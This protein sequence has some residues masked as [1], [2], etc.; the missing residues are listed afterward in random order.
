MDPLAWRP[1]GACEELVSADTGCT[2]WDPG[3]RRQRAT[4]RKRDR[5]RLAA[6]EAKDAESLR[7]LRQQDQE[8]ALR[9]DAKARV[10]EFQRMMGVGQ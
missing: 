6:R 8:R 7:R 5:D 9:A 1:C 2:H 10:A 4:M 3:F